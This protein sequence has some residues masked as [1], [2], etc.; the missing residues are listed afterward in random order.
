MKEGSDNEVLVEEKQEE[1][2]RKDPWLVR[3]WPYRLYRAPEV[4][5]R[6]LGVDYISHPVVRWSKYHELIVFLNKVYF[7]PLNTPPK[8]LENLITFFVITQLLIL[9]WVIVA[10]LT[11]ERIIFPQI[12]QNHLVDYLLYVPFVIFIIS[13][14][15][16]AQFGLRKIE[17]NIKENGTGFNRLFSLH[18]P[19]KRIDN[20]PQLK[21]HLYH[22]FLS[23]LSFRDFAATHHCLALFHRRNDFNGLSIFR[24]LLIVI[25]SVEAYCYF[26]CL[27]LIDDSGYHWSEALWEV[28]PFTP[29]YCATALFA[30]W[31]LWPILL[32]MTPQARLIE[33]SNLIRQPF[34]EINELKSYLELFWPAVRRIVALVLIAVPLIIMIFSLTAWLATKAENHT[35]PVVLLVVSLPFAV[36][37]RRLTRY[38]RLKAHKDWRRKIKRSERQFRE[39]ANRF[40]YPAPDAET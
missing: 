11:L 24:Q 40:E 13:S 14:I 5:R 34:Y 33:E 18:N 17:K 2:D 35:L 27:M 31:A 38:L 7:I 8:T 32:Q 37:R 39:F 36:V 23:N 22:L 26:I 28:I 20:T 9:G 29:F 15:I 4:Y 6:E 25:Y 16:T 3:H 30:G 10:I 1:A 12:P 19:R 21:N